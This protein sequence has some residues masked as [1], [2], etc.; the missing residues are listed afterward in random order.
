MKVG[1]Q[2]NLTVYDEKSNFIGTMSQGFDEDR[3]WRNHIPKKKLGNRTCAGMHYPYQ[4]NKP[5][6]GL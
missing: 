3:K 2:A 1:D 5:E 4:K 6:K